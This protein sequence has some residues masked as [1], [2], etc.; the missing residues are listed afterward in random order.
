[1]RPKSRARVVSREIA[2]VSGFVVLNHR[3][4]SGTRFTHGSIHVIIH[5]L[6]RSVSITVFLK[7]LNILSLR[8]LLYLLLEK[9][10]LEYNS[11]KE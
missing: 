11:T 1:M 7:W 6:T 3:K 2:V 8:K 10:M 4:P 9:S 5:E